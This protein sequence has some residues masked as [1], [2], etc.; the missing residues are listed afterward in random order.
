VIFDP[1]SQD[2]NDGATSLWQAAIAKKRKSLKKKNGT[3][4]EQ[5][6]IGR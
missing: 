6:T 4:L 5:R 3:L 2:E 1:Q